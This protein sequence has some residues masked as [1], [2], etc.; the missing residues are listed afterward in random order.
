[1]IISE[2]SHYEQIRISL[3]KFSKGNLSLKITIQHTDIFVYTNTRVVECCSLL[4][5]G[6]MLF[7]CP[8]IRLNFSRVQYCAGLSLHPFHTAGLV[9]Q[10]AP[11]VDSRC[12]RSKHVCP[13]IRLAGFLIRLG[14]SSSVLAGNSSH[15]SESSYHGPSGQVGPL[16]VLESSVPSPSAWLRQGPS[17]PDSII[18][19]T[20]GH[21]QHQFK[22][23]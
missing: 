6:R 2:N 15:Q 17:S 12:C 1:M 21:R 7:L 9:E 20:R 23:I 18:W 10:V 4:L 13:G 3:S 16:L 8:H 5:H 14:T 19:G 22:W 11:S